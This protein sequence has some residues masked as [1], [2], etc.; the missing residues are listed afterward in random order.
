MQIKNVGAESISAP[1]CGQ[2]KR[3][4][5]PSLWTG[6]VQNTVRP[7]QFYIKEVTLNSWNQPPIFDLVM[8]L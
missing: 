2:S 7:W 6:R 1:C 5:Q 4:F 8:V 3:D